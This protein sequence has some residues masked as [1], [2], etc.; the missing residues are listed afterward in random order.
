MVLVLVLI[1][2]LR[3]TWGVEAET[4]QGRIDSCRL[5]QHRKHP[6]HTWRCLW[7]VDQLEKVITEFDDEIR[8]GWSEFCEIVVG[9]G[10]SSTFGLMCGQQNIRVLGVSQ[11]TCEF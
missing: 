3:R 5:I 11:A 2:A 10:K 8:H 6:L 7:I 1:L 4:H 9:R